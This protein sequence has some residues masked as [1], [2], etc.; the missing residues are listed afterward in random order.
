MSQTVLPNEAGY[1]LFLKFQSSVFGGIFFVGY[2]VKFGV[3]WHDAGAPFVVNDIK[4]SAYWDMILIIYTTLG[5]YYFQASTNPSGYKPLLSWSMWGGNL[6]HGIV[7]LIHCFDGD[8]PQ[9][10]SAR[11]QTE[12]FGG[13]LNMDKLILAV[14]LWFGMFA[15]NLYFTNKCFGS[16]L[17]PWNSANSLDSAVSSK[18][19]G[20]GP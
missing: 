13:N 12:A 16:S 18:L 14:P 10:A 5:F 7:A 9:A 8:G 3:A 4:F 19:A 20:E 1:S 6:C 17:L 2:F 11:Y 15:A